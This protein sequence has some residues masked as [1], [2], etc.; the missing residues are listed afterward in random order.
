MTAQQTFDLMIVAAGNGT[1]MGDVTLPKILTKINGY[2]NLWNTLDKWM[3]V[4]GRGKTYIVANNRNSHLIEIYVND[5]FIQLKE[6]QKHLSDNDIAKEKELIQI[7]KI[8]SGRGDG[9]AV[10]TAAH[11]LPLSKFFF[12]VWGDAYF[13]SWNI[14]TDCI[15]EYHRNDSKGYFM[16]IPVIN[17]KNPYVTF[18]VDEKM[19]CVAADFSKRGENHPSG[20]H[21]QCVF[22]CNRARIC[23]LLN[24]M[25]N[26]YFKNGRYVTDSGELTFLYLVHLLHNLH[27]PAKALV[28]DSPVLSY[29]TTGEVKEIEKS[30]LE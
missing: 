27:N 2:P 28:T 3:V 29:N 1:R 14:F 6:K 9:H 30:L 22:F 13:T 17:E 23:E 24:V 16:Y 10:M 5:Y 25:H 8:E 4:P 20:F 11:P 12:V 19:E 26:V 7:V 21:D 15:D 18:I